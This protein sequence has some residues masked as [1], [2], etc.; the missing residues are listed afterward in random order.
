MNQ[1]RQ[2]LLEQARRSIRHGL[3]QGHAAG[4]S[5]TDFSTALQDMRASFVTLNIADK[6]RGCIGHLEPMRPLVEDVVENAWSAAFRDPRFSPLGTHEFDD[7]QIHISVLSVPEAMEFDDEAELLAQLRPGVDGLILAEA[8]RSATFL[9]SVW[10]S[11]S[12]RQDFLKHLKQKA[13]FH[14]D[15]WSLDMR[16]SRYVTESFP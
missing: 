11:L 14:H 6:L 10:D 4:V 5:A 3:D 15:Y 13:G 2:T 12:D 1:D 7:L 16:A 9:P 8:G